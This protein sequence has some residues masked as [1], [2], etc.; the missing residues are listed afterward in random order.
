MLAYFPAL[1]SNC[2]FLPLPLV[3]LI[4]HQEQYNFVLPS[5]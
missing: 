2:T 1:R 5:V 3:T 4:K